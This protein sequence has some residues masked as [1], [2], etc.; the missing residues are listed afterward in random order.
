[1]L[2][3]SIVEVASFNV[4]YKNDLNFF[5]GKCSKL[6]FQIISNKG[7]SILILTLSAKFEKTFLF[8]IDK[9]AWQERV[10]VNSKIFQV[11]LIVSSEAVAT[12]IEPSLLY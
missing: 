7:K 4:G 10:F 6:Y 5:Y 3:N 2:L 12:Y 11:N 8:I 9:R 1:M